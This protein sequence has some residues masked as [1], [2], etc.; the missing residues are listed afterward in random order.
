MSGRWL[1]TREDGQVCGG[2]ESERLVI[3]NASGYGCAEGPYAEGAPRSRGH[4]ST[5]GCHPGVAYEL[6]TLVAVV[7]RIQARLD[8]T[9]GF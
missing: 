9:Q 3:V 4:L 8:L 7:A 2:W 6:L 1:E 5:T